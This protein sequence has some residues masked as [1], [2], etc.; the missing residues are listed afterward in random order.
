MRRLLAILLLF[1]LV[2]CS[3]DDVA[4]LNR[5]YFLGLW[6][7]ETNQS[8]NN[9]ITYQF[10]ADGRYTLSSNPGIA[11]P[12]LWSYNDQ[13][14][15]LVMTGSGGVD[16][17]TILYHTNDRFESLRTDDQTLVFFQRIP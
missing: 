9:Q 6:E 2:R 4:P 17:Y 16:T 14:R 3:D 11:A 5:N 10:N 7:I 8:F 12:G 15:E 1:L 13:T